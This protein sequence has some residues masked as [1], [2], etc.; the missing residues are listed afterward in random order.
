MSLLNC[1]TNSTLSSSFFFF[2]SY[3]STLSFLFYFFPPLN[4]MSILPLS[5]FLP[6][7]FPLYIEFSTSE[8]KVTGNVFNFYFFIIIICMHLFLYVVFQTKVFA[9]TPCYSL[10]SLLLLFFLSFFFF[11]NNIFLSCYC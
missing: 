1:S 8:K 3:L 9:Q 11:Q 4:T 7:P 5:L 6:R 10:S 2:S